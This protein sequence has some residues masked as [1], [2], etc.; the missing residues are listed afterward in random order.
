MRTQRIAKFAVAL[1]APLVLTQAFAPGPASASLG[2]QNTDPYS[3][4]CSA[5]S[6]TL[7]SRGVPGGT[8]SVKVSNACG[9]NW[10]EYSGSTQWT[11]KNVAGPYGTPGLPEIDTRP[12]A[13]SMQVYAPG[14][15]QVTA[16]VWGNGWSTR[17]SCSTT[18]SWS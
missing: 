5:T 12:W 18:C 6:W 13:Y 4:G 14:T 8:V 7:S 9:T 1:A 16:Y 15:S 2:H 3:T 10:V 17:A 11:K